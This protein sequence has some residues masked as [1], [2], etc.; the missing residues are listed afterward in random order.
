MPNQPVC[1]PYHGA[2]N[3]QNSMHQGF[4]A[5]TPTQLPPPPM[6]P[7]SPPSGYSPYAPAAHATSWQQQGPT[8]VAQHE[9]NANGGYVMHAMPQMHTTMVQGAQSTNMQGAYLQPPW[10]A[11]AK[12]CVDDQCAMPGCGA[13][14]ANANDQGTSQQQQQQQQQQRSAEEEWGAQRWRR[15]CRR[16]TSSAARSTKATAAAT[17]TA[18]AA[19]A[20]TAHRARTVMA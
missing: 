13:T 5:P 14:N 2:Y 16:P 15:R 12:A 3:M 11:H 4:V 19:T 20:A 6:T 7:M 18:T 10:Q 8:N 17:T 1:S 9:F